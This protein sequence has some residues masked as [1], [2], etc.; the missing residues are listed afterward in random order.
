V[1]GHDDAAKVLVDA[2]PPAAVKTTARWHV[3]WSVSFIMIAPFDWTGFRCS[4]SVT[5]LAFQSARMRICGIIV[6]LARHQ[7]DYPRHIGRPRDTTAGRHYRYAFLVASMGHQSD[8]SPSDLGVWRCS[9]VGHHDA[10][11]FGET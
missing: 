11:I 5:R 9:S 7:K 10:R 1:I 8:D 3:S 2:T 6:S 4:D